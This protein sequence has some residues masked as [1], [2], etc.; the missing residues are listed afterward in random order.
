MDERAGRRRRGRVRGR[1]DGADAGDQNFD[2]GVLRDSVRAVATEDQHAGGPR[3]RL[4][5]ESSR[6]GGNE[7][8]RVG[9]GRGVRVLQQFDAEARG[10]ESAAQRET[11]SGPRVVEQQAGHDGVQSRFDG[12]RGGQSASG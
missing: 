9:R 5:A 1:I 4:A 3:S 8:D 2:R 10:L 11:A 12:T 7:Q 6:L